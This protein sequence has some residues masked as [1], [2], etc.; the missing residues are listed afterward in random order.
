MN[1]NCCN[2]SSNSSCGDNSEIKI[3]GT[4]VNVTV[5][6][7][8]KDDRDEQHDPCKAK[9]WPSNVTEE[10]HNGA[11][12]YAYQLHDGRFR[13][14]DTN[15]K[16][17]QRF[18]D[19]INKRVTN[20]TFDPDTNITTIEGDTHIEN[21]YIKKGDQW[22]KIEDAN[23][24]DDTWLK[25]ENSE[26]SDGIIGANPDN[27][28]DRK[29]ELEDVPLYPNGEKDDQ[30]NPIPAVN[31]DNIIDFILAL[32][33]EINNLRGRIQK[34]EGDDTDTCLWMTSGDGICPRN[35]NAKVYSDKGFFDRSL[36]NPQS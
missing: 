32:S 22:V 11:L 26:G 4:L 27:Y 12:A 2:C 8:L 9:N 5:D 18:Q 33:A 10:G 13:Q 7:D 21:L 3:Y 34:L 36:E 19:E 6:K 15:T 28:N 24:Y 20:I 35:T 14:N 17:W 29:D 31:K 1:C 16:P 25:G 23:S 30:D